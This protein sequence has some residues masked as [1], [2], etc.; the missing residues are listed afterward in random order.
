L[1]CVDPADLAHSRK[2]TRARPHSRGG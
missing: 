1:P 2:P